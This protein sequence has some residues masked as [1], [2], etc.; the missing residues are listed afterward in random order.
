MLESNKNLINFFLPGHL[1]N[2]NVS[3]IFS[4]PVTN[5][6]RRSNPNPKPACGTL[7]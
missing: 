7:P 2:G 3:L 1:G 6:T 5:L 4:I